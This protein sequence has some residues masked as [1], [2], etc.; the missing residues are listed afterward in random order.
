MARRLA[1]ASVKLKEGLTR[2]EARE[3]LALIEKLA[4]PESLAWCK[5]HEGCA[6]VSYNDEH[7]EPS[8]FYVP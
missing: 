6:I 8:L 5:K 1:L 3:L 4:E 7:G 2:G